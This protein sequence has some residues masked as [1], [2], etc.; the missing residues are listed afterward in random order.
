M[1]EWKNERM[2]NPE[3]IAPIAIEGD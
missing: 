2:K 3:G 1:K